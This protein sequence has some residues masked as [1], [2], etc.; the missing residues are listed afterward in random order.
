M[1]RRSQITRL[2][3]GVA[4]AS[5]LSFALPAFGG[6]R[7]I[8]SSFAALAFGGGEPVT[9]DAVVHTYERL[10]REVGGAELTPEIV[11]KMQASGEPLAI[12]KDVYLK[13]AL[14]R[15]L[16]EFR[17]L[18]ERRFPEGIPYRAELLKALG[19]LQERL[20]VAQ[21][22]L[23]RVVTKNEVAV[24]TH[25]MTRPMPDRMRR[26]GDWIVGVGPEYMPKIQGK[27]SKWTDPYAVYLVD[28]S[29]NLKEVPYE[30]PADCLGVVVSEVNPVS[31]EIFI[32]DRGNGYG[33]W[34]MTVFD[35]QGQPLAR[36][37]VERVKVR[38]GAGETGRAFDDLLFTP[39]GKVAIGIDDAQGAVALP[40]T[41]AARDGIQPIPLGPVQGGGDQVNVGTV[42]NDHIYLRRGN[43][44]K[45]VHVNGT[46]SKNIPI[47]EGYEEAFGSPDGKT[48]YVHYRP[49]GQKPYFEV[50]DLGA[51]GTPG[52]VPRKFEAGHPNPLGETTDPVKDQIFFPPD[53]PYLIQSYFGQWRED[54]DPKRQLRVLNPKTFELLGTFDFPP[55]QVGQI[56]RLHLSAD[57]SKI[58]GH[59]EDRA[60][61][62]GLNTLI[63]RVDV[64]A[65][66]ARAKAP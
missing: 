44:L 59:Q 20:Q 47:Q 18:L 29:G 27:R 17:R 28:R 55:L 42:G 31:G 9:V 21:S 65:V 60:G 57:G 32:S 52:A 62:N 12:P 46:G 14:E 15:Q 22:E 8:C 40:L 63:Y 37:K 5:L 19:T 49:T 30:L 54:R 7:P 34:K 41:N 13:G 26:F 10:L 3:W 6:D 64:E 1:T 50:H 43:R 11:A 16:E 38:Q 53:S 51:V 4:V 48:L 36:A 39:D 24:E 45:V 25:T 66:L 56:G 2:S 23:N 35:G 58:I 61:L 33:L